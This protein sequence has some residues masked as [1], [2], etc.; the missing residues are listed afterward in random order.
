M[1]R[2]AYCSAFFA[3]IPFRS[4]DR[5]YE[6]VGRLARVNRRRAV[7]WRGG[8][9]RRRFCA[10]PVDV[11]KGRIGCG[12]LVQQ[13]KQRTQQ[14]F[15]FIARGIGI[16]GQPLDDFP[17]QSRV[18]AVRLGVGGPTLAKGRHAAAEGPPPP[19]G[20]EFEIQQVA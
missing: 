13:F 9:R 4:R 20:L 16:L 2:R 11:L 18:R 19:L 7:S 15:T 6:R 1:P 10:D 12:R 8:R 3:P 5:I 14:P 17:Q